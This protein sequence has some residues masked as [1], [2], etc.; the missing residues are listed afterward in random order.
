MGEQLSIDFD[1]AIAAGEAASEACHAKADRVNP[2]FSEGAYS[3][4]CDYIAA[5]PYTVNISCEVL[6]TAAER[7]GHKPHD[8]RAFGQVFRRLVK[9][10]R[11]RRVGYGMRTKGHGAPGAS[12]YVRVA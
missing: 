12:I 11:I 5:L 3:F 2:G 6:V 1:A 10:N 9:D 8:S 4:L 7:A